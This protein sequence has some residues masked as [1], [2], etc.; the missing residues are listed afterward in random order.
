[1][2]DWTNGWLWIIAALLL[3]LVELILPGYIFMGMAGA[4]AVMGLLLLTGL[5]SAGLPW[6][7]VATAVLSGVIW[8]VLSRLRGVDR[9]AT[10]IWRDDINDNPPRPDGRPDNGD[11]RA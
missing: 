6:A 3:A 7:L 2:T 4:T 10:R 5:W 1:M 8:F 9:S 11:P